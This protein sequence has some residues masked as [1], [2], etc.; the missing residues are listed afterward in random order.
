M[1]LPPILQTLERCG[2]KRSQITILIATGMHRPNLAE[3]L[4]TLLGSEI[5]ERYRVVNHYCRQR[6][7]VRRVGA[8]QLAALGNHCPGGPQSSPLEINRHYLD[9]ELKILTGLIEPHFYAGFSGGCKSILPG[10]SSFETM[11]AMHSFAMIEHPEVANTHLEGNPFHQ[12]VL[13]AA[14]LASVDFIVNVVINRTRQ[15]AGV[16]AGHHDH[17]HRAGCELAARHSTQEI[18]APVDLVVTSGGGFPLDA[19]FYQISKALDG[20]RQI[21]RPGGALVVA[22]ECREGLGG[23]EFTDILRT[24]DGPHGFTRR[25]GDAQHFVIDQ[26]CAQSIYQAIEHAGE[27]LIFSTRSQGGGSAL[28]RGAADPGASARRG[29]APGRSLPGPSLP[30]CGGP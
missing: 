10:I 2:L 14:D 29:P 30:G 24:T 1:L 9:A 28:D 4:V 22:C 27:V 11:K 19:T 20:A 5:L 18:E 17:A 8:L 16:F 13:R 3:E 23:P 6:E 21:L 12:A 7:V 25:F 26:W 15:V